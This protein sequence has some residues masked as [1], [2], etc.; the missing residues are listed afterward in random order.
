MPQKPKAREAKKIVPKSA[1]WEAKRDPKSTPGVSSFRHPA[2]TWP[3]GVRNDPGED[4][5][6]L[7]A[8]LETQAMQNSF[9]TK[10]RM[11]ARL[12]LGGKGD[13]SAYWLVHFHFP[14]ENELREADSQGRPREWSGGAVTACGGAVTVCGV[15]GSGVA[16]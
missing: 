9:S 16:V 6:V 13:P 5:A 10:F 15:E 4:A 2:A 1:L 12:T 3:T 11:Q 8:W 7:T 14:L